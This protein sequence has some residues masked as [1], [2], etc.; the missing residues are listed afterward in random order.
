MTDTAAPAAGRTPGQGLLIGAL[1]GVL[2]F[3]VYNANGREIASADSQAAKFSSVMLARRHALSLDGVVGRQPLYGER[4]A[5]VRDRQGHWRNSYPLPPVLEA[6]AVASVLRGLG[7]LSLEAPLA[8]A[9]VAKITASLL[10]SIAAVLAFL[11]ARRLCA[12]RQAMFV[13]VGFALGTGLWP[14]ASQT[15]WQH[16]SA[17]CSLMAAVAIWTASTGRWTPARA[18]AAGA[19]LGWSLSARPQTLPIIGIVTA[20]LM[21]D[22]PPRSRMSLLIALLTPVAIF[23]ALNLVWFGDPGGAQPQ[24][25]QLTLSVHNVRSTWQAPLAGVAGLLASPSRGL[26]VFSPIVLVALLARAPA[27]W[28][29]LLRWTLAAAAAQ[30][31][32]YGSYSV[33]WGG[34]TYG[35]RYALDLLPVLVPAAALGADRLARSRRA[36]RAIGG[37]ALAWSILVAATGAFCYPYEQW[38]NDPV[39][40]DQ[41]HERLWEIRDSQIPRCWSR[42]LAPQ[43]FVLFDRALWKKPG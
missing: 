29:P 1:L 22:T 20:G 36:F 13:A 16:A 10:T 33:W 25:Q 8:P 40:L 41:A 11:T 30:L 27:P 2:V 43:N 39:N 7:L 14:T 42:G 12:A 5:F 23:A 38:N 3:A 15:L 34:Y 19:L 35:P 28:Q 32:L 9:I 26:L 17:T 21:F 6:A 18:A 4:Q 37:V 24:F 31:L